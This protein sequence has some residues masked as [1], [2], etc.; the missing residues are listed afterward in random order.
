MFQRLMILFV[1]VLM[2]GLVGCDSG[3]NRSPADVLGIAANLS[4]VM[5]L[6]PAA[7]AERLTGGV[8]R[9]VCEPLLEIGRAHV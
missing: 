5:T 4:S 3:T 7:V 1:V 6:D 8:I 2:L 9:N